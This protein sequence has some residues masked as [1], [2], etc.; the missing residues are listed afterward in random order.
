MTFVSPLSP[1]PTADWPAARNTRLPSGLELVVTPLTHLH[2][3]SIVLFVRVGSRYEDAAENGLSHLVEH[4]LFRGCERFPDTYE[5]NA[6][7][8]SIGT[9]IDAATSRDFTT[10]EATCLHRVQRTQPVH[11][12]PGFLLPAH[13]VVTAAEVEPGSGE[14]GLQLDGCAERADCVRR[15]TGLQERGTK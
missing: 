3:A 2:L 11:D 6:A 12:G 14:I 4:V 1:V 15:P 13:Q 7:I 5:L 8:E 9:G 10:F